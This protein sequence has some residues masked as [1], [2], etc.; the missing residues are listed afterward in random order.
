MFSGTNRRFLLV[1]FNRF[2]FLDQV[3]HNGIANSVTLRLVHLRPRQHVVAHVVGLRPVA[4]QLLQVAVGQLAHVGGVLDEEQRGGNGALHVVGDGGHDRVVHDHGLRGRHEGADLVAELHAAEEA[5]DGLVGDDGVVEGVERTRA[6]GVAVHLV[7]VGVVDRVHVRVVAEDER[8]HVVLRANAGAGQHHRVDRVLGGR[9]SGGEVGEVLVVCVVE[10]GGGLGDGLRVRKGAGDDVDHLADAARAVQEERVV[11]VRELFSDQ[12]V[13]HRLV[14]LGDVDRQVVVVLV[15]ALRA[16]VRQGELRFTT[17]PTAYGDRLQQKG[18]Q[19]VVGDAAHMHAG[20]VRRSQ[21][22]VLHV[23]GG[24]RGQEVVD[25]LLTPCRQGDLLLG[26]VEAIAREGQLGLVQRVAHDE[27]AV[28]VHLSG[29][30]LRQSGGV[31]VEVQLRAVLQPLGALEVLHVRFV[32]SFVLGI[33]EG[34]E[35]DLHFLSKQ[36][37]RLH[38]LDNVELDGLRRFRKGTSSEERRHSLHSKA[39]TMHSFANKGEHDGSQL[40]F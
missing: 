3:L 39:S 30:D 34:V 10:R 7:Q 26:I 16:H 20:S 6:E 13:L 18:G 17:S 32:A 2:H 37:I 8:G 40:L 21:L 5:V 23:D 11:M 15:V 29:N 33:T 9:L 28:L 38:I 25:L 14:A 4:H 35:T 19:R 12:A 22:S 31:G 27:V 1:V 36:G 24:L